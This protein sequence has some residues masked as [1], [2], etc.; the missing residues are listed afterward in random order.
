MSRR[1]AR[2]V[3][4]AVLAFVS[5]PLLGGPPDVTAKIAELS[6]APGGKG[7]VVVELTM[8]TG[9]HVNSHE[10]LEEFLVPTV[11]TLTTASGQRLPVRY[12]AAERKRFA[13]SEKPLSVYAG[14]VRFEADVTL[15]ADARD[16]LGLSGEVSYQACTDEQCFRPAR[17]PL[18]G[19]VRV[20]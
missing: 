17:I 4:C 8:G 11:V 13:F 18:E 2:A 16:P 7:S 10:P 6:L 12:P 3:F 1:D 19:K 15:P 20:R 14:T 9:W 5:A